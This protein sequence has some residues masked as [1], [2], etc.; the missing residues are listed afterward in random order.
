MYVYMIFMCLLI[1]FYHSIIFTIFII[2]IVWLIYT[3]YY[4]LREDAPSSGHSFIQVMAFV[5]ND[6]SKFNERNK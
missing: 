4:S 1:I 5:L 2:F 3:R 6:S